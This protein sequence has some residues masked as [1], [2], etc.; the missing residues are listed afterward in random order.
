MWKVLHL[1]TVA[2]SKV[3]LSLSTW[4]H[5][6]DTNFFI[7]I[8]TYVYCYTALI[9]IFF[10]EYKGFSYFTLN[11]S[12][13]LPQSIYAQ[14]FICISFLFS[15][16]S[17]ENAHRFYMF[18][19]LMHKLSH[20]NGKLLK[21]ITKVSGSIRTF[22]NP[23]AHSWTELYAVWWDS[24]VKLVNFRQINPK[25]LELFH[26]TPT[27]KLLWYFV[28]LKNLFHFKCVCGCGN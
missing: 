26:F 5:P 7:Q 19:S 21:I 22:R 24:C 9:I 6:I 28:A 20:R 25:E 23:S 12:W 8:E 4:C 10:L 13:T 14:F 18:T 17:Y 3:F 1:F 27:D 2:D 15:S 11:L 16:Y